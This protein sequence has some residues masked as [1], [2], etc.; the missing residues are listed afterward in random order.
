[1][2]ML[3]TFD[4]RIVAYDYTLTFRIARYLFKQENGL[5][6]PICQ[7]I[8]GLIKRIKTFICHQN[9]C[10]INAC[11]VALKKSKDATPKIKNTASYFVK[12]ATAVPRVSSHKYFRSIFLTYLVRK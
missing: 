12:N 11:L 4:I 5:G 2:Y 7:R 10:C 8:F 1:F 6:L 9:L 3:L